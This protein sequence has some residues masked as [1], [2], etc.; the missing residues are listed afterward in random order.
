MELFL[1]RFGGKAL[2]WVGMSVLLA[3]SGAWAA[4]PGGTAL[5]TISPGP[6]GVSVGPGA[7]YTFS[8][9]LDN[10]APGR[11]SIA[12]FPVQASYNV[13]AGPGGFLTFNAGYEY[14]DYDWTEADFFGATHRLSLSAVGV[15]QIADSSWG[16][17]G[18]GQLSWAAETGAPLGRGFSS[19]LVVGPAYSFSRDLSLTV[20]PLVS[21]Q[22]ERSARVFPVAGLNWRIN[23]QWSARTLNGVIVTY[24]P[25][26]EQR[27]QVDVSAEYRSRGIR[28]RRQL[29][30]DGSDDR[31]AVSEREIAVGVG[32]AWQMTDHLILRGA[33]EYLFARRWNFR[34]GETQFDRVEAKSAPQVGMRLEYV[35]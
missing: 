30:P 4:T 27:I 3:G 11:V 31:P 32:G 34:A 5:G 20:G 21:L 13:P 35:F 22:P 25:D 24:A 7:T 23:E 18:F 12:R 8:A 6:V 15:R 2:S 33:V 26:V 29:L 16:V 28:L 9:D 1:G 10:P 17:F 19:T 14:A